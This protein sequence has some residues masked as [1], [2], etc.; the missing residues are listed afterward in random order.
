MPAPRRVRHDPPMEIVHSSAASRARPAPV[1]VALDEVISWGCSGKGW[2]CCTDKAIP[3]KPYD[4]VRLR[5]ATSKPSQALINERIVH[6]DWDDA[7]T[8]AGWLAQRPY[9]ANRVA[10]LFFEEVT[11]RDAVRMRAEDPERFAAMPQAVRD[12]AD[13]PQGGT[14]RV[15]GLCGV[16]QGRPGACRGYP[17]QRDPRWS[18]HPERAAGQIFNCGSCALAERTTVREVMLDNDLVP[19]WQ[20]DDAYR[21]VAQYLHARG[22]ANISD[23]R[24]RALPVDLQQ[25]ANVWL[26]LYVPDA[27][28]RVRAAF[29]DHWLTPHDIEGDRQVYRMLLEDVLDRADAMV[30]A[31]GID[32]ERLGGPGA[33]AERPDIAALLAP[34][35]EALPPPAVIPLTLASA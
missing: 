33:T 2:N 16:H 28:P 30:A 22:F 14:W 19:F 25:R 32:P 35:R 29:P 15:A 26:A 8:L 21:A 13:R 20:A 23:R 1:P 6:F 4:M 27:N 12:A 31:S 18:D 34:A 5:H 7:G 9:E 3:V 11:N 17:F 10:C 24:Y